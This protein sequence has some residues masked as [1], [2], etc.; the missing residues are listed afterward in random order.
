MSDP[1]P[2]SK[3]ENHTVSAS[4]PGGLTV[5]VSTTAGLNAAIQAAKDMLSFVNHNFVKR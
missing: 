5:S 4:A 1:A 2:P 3:P